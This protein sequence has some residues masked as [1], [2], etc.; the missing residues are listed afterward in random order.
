MQT[1]FIEFI[2][3]F[4]QKIKIFCFQALFY[5]HVSKLSKVMVFKIKLDYPN[6]KVSSHFFCC[7]V[8]REFIFWF[9]FV[10]GLKAPW[11]SRYNLFKKF[12]GKVRF[13]WGNLNINFFFHLCIEHYFQEIKVGKLREY[14]SNTFCKKKSVWI[15]LHQ[16]KK[17]IVF[18]CVIASYFMV[19]FHDNNYNNHTVAVLW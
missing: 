4:K 3:Q 9:L 19:I 13:F 11:P 5:T 6:Y 14:V 18:F 15:F 12:W 16:R 17:K 7:W 8:G 1:K 10:C 2:S